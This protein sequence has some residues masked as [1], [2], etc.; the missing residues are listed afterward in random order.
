ML[1]LS[2]VEFRN[3]PLAYHEPSDVEFAAFLEVHR[4]GDVE[5]MLDFGDG[6]LARKLRLSHSDLGELRLAWSSVRSHRLRHGRPG[7]ASTASSDLMR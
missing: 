5:A 1:E 4:S 7:P 3:L 2:P 6:W